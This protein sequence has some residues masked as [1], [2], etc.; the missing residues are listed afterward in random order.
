MLLNL[1]KKNPAN[2]E[3][4]ILTKAVETGRPLKE[5]LKRVNTYLKEDPINAPKMSAR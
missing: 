5:K 1:Y 2:E 3:P 4:I